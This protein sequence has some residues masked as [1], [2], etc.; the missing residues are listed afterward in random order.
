MS[1]SSLNLLADALYNSSTTLPSSLVSYAELTNIDEVEAKA[2]DKRAG[3]GNKEQLQTATSTPKNPWAFNK[4][5]VQDISFVQVILVVKNESS[6]ISQSWEEE[7]YSFIKTFIKQKGFCAIC[8]NGTQ[9]HLHILL[10][11]VGKYDIGLTVQQLK[12][13]TAEFINENCRQEPG[14]GAAQFA[15]HK[16]YGYSDYPHSMVYDVISKIKSQKELHL[17]RDFK[18]EYHG[19]MKSNTIRHKLDA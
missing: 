6:F 19:M 13:R 1:K 16:G 10:S 2:D 14:P 17:V 18:Q 11:I 15:W 8:V 7:L 4:F 9:D 3:I 12:E 5:L